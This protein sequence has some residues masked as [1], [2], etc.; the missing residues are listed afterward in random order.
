MANLVIAKMSS[1][2]RVVIPEDIRR[3]LRLKEGSQF[4]VLG[5]DD[6]VVLK[7]I[8]PPS[9]KEFDALIAKV[10]RQAKEAGLT[11]TDVTA[12]IAEVRGRE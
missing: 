12:V 5:E 6:V 3:R 9:I 7:V 1:K 10:R 8:V 4:V 11:P 2:G